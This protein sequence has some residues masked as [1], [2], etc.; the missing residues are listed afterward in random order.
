MVVFFENIWIWIGLAMAVGV[1]GFVLFQ[2]NQRV[3]TF[4]A[5]A[6][7]VILLLTVGFSLY[8][9]VDTDRKSVIRVLNKLA[10]ALEKDDF[11]L[12]CQFI[13]AKAVH[14]R[15]LARNGMEFVVVSRASFSNLHVNVNYMTNPPIAAVS[16]NAMIYWKPKSGWTK[17][18]FP[19]DKPVPDRVAFDLEL[20]KTNNNSWLITNKCDYQYRG[21]R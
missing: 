12:V 6:V 14:T 21:F 20:R 11:D 17:N 15:S 3:V 2:N 13:D 5:T 7:S 18:E 10:A 9:F 1:I 16:F 19:T 8:Y 4:W